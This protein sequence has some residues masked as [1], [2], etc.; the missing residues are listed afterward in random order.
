MVGRPVG[1]ARLGRRLHPTQNNGAHTALCAHI[2]FVAVARFSTMSAGQ[3]AAAAVTIGGAALVFMQF[4]REDP[5]VVAAMPEDVKRNPLKK[6]LSNAGLYPQPDEK[7]GL[8]RTASGS[9]AVFSSGEPGAALTKG[10]G[11]PL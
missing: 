2:A 10:G 1:F 5:A 11:E 4:S 7:K 6:T 9:M 8:Q 3:L